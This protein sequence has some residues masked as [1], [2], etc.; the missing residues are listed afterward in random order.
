MVIDKVNGLSVPRYLVYDIIRFMDEDFME[1]P[2]FPDRLECIRVQVVG[3]K[4]R[5]LRKSSDLWSKLGWVRVSVISGHFQHFDAWMHGNFN[6]DAES[7]ALYWPRI[8][9]ENILYLIFMQMLG[10]RPCNTIWSTNDASRLV[11]GKKISGMSSVPENYCHQNLR[12][13]CATNQTD[14]YFNRRST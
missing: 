3:E 2:F 6:A 11:C 10:I 12:N 4:S 9:N 8:L 13:R 14:W 5:K 1:R 7:D